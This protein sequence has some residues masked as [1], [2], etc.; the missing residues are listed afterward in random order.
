MRQMPCIGFIAPMLET[1][2]LFDSSG[3]GQVHRITGFHQAIDQPILVV[4]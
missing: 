4:G 1:I 2:V 3:I